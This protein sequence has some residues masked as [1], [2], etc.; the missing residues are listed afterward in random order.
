ME[1]NEIMINAFVKTEIESLTGN[2]QD[3]Q[4]VIID[5]KGN[6]TKKIF[7][8]ELVEYMKRESKN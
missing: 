2:P 5:S 6:R 3:W 4:V 8:D 7:M 1:V